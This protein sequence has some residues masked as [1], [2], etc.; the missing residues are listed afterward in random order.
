MCGIVGVINKQSSAYSR[1]ECVTLINSLLHHSQSRGK[2]SS[3]IAV[4][5]NGKITVVKA[6]VSADRLVAT[7]EFADAVKGKTDSF[8]AIGHARMETNGSFANKENNQP[9]IK[10]GIVAIHNGIIVNDSQLW[11]KYP[12][13]K[14]VSEVD[15]EVFNSILRLKISKEE[16]LIKALKD[17]LSELKGAYSFGVLFEDQNYI[18]LVTNTGSLFTARNSNNTLFFFG[19]EKRFL[20]K[21]LNESILF[22][23]SED[24]VI[25][26]VKANTGLLINLE[27]LHQYY[28]EIDSAKKATLMPLDTVSKR[29]ISIVY[30]QLKS[31][32]KDERVD[33]SSHYKELT[34]VIND[35]YLAS[36]EKIKQLRR[37]TRCILPETMPFIRFDKDG[38]CNYCHHHQPRE[39]RGADELE[40][41]VSLHRR[42][43]GNPDCIVAFSGGRDS[44]YA[45]HYVK[46]ELGLTPLAYSYDWGM[47]TDLGR[48]NQAR[49]TGQLGVQHILVSAD[50]QKKRK[51]IRKN[52][53]AWLNKPHI[54]I[55]PLFMAGDKQYFYYLNKLRKDTK[56]PLVIYGDNAL[57]KTDFKYGFAGIKLS[58]EVGKAYN[59]G[60]G[61]SL[62]LLWFYFSQYMKNPAYMNDSLFDTFTAYISSYFVDKTY[63]YMFRYL[64]WDEKEIENTLLNQYDWETSPDTKSTWRIGDGTASF[65]NYVYYIVTGLTEN[66]TFRSNQIREGTISRKEA[67][68]RSEEDNRPRI[69]SILWYCDTIGIDALAAIKKINS[70]EKL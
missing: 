28:F 51:Y 32:N 46:K 13:L 19:S 55:V 62:S 57:E 50:I 54:G 35:E 39:T 53:L 6:A 65:Y 27:T 43:D 9:I 5:N 21:A 25:N 8:A 4:V 69:D 63:V 29:D 68:I 26:Q 15:T 45:L 7:K 11:K 18:L 14:R 24:I 66:D 30:P 2:D 59:I 23:Q 34:K 36:K 40:K 33:N 41:A 70:I 44:S 12:N 16:S 10:D 1:K 17:T 47:L 52:V 49:M 61:N 31:G 64:L 67:L 60:L 56:I 22:E 42:S 58:S 3:G 20:E 38:V 48:R 37:C